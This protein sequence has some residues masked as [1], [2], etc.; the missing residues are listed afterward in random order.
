MSKKQL[1]LESER[2][3][4][5][6]LRTAFYSDLDIAVKCESTLRDN[7]ILNNNIVSESV[8][9]FFTKFT[10]NLLL[11]H[12]RSQYVFQIKSNQYFWNTKE[13]EAVNIFIQNFIADHKKVIKQYSDIA[14]CKL[15]PH[16]LVTL[17]PEL[18]LCGVKTLHSGKEH[19][20]NI[21]SLLLQL[22]I[23]QTL[24]KYNCNDVQVKYLDQYI[25][26]LKKHSVELHNLNQAVRGITKDFHTH[27]YMDCIKY[28]ADLILLSHNAS[29][30]FIEISSGVLK[31][32]EGYLDA[33]DFLLGSAV[34]ENEA[35]HGITG[36]NYL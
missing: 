7:A 17:F 1:F 36:Y 2:T 30:L 21:E 13:S 28:E 14:V 23:H 12:A 27:G 6:T 31:S 25:Q 10:H 26:S 4:F 32:S 34:L 35:L 5:L 20:N 33:I 22:D 29:K 11:S 19:L 24:I 18:G 15:N 3:T 16:C 9:N 8:W